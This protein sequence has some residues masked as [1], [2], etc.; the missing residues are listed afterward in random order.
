MWWLIWFCSC[1][2]ASSPR[3]GKL[4]AGS[5]TARIVDRP[6]KA[7]AKAR[8][9]LEANGFDLAKLIEAEQ[10]STVFWWECNENYSAAKMNKAIK[11]KTSKDVSSVDDMSNI[12]SNTNSKKKN[13]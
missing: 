5:Q 4:W 8:E 11:K 6:H 12:E 10:A 9:L 13:S 3:H 2:R 1:A 7:E